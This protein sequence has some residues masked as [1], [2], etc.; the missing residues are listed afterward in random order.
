MI[1]ET[2][3]TAMEEIIFRIIGKHYKVSER[4]EDTT[5]NDNFVLHD[6]ELYEILFFSE[7]DAKF[8]IEGKEYFLESGD[9]I[10]VRKHEMHRVYHN[11]DARY[12]RIV[13]F[14][15]PEFFNIH[16]CPNYE[17]QFLNSQLGIANRIK[18]DYVR[19]CGLYDA[20]KRLRRYSKNY[21]PED[22]AVVEAIIIEILYLINRVGRFSSP[23][24]HE[25]Q[26]V[27]VISYINNHYTEDIDL[28]T[29]EKKFYTSRYHLCKIFRKA[30]GLTIHDYIRRKRLTRVREL[31]QAG[32]NITDAAM[33]SGF[34]DYS[35]FYR[36]YKKMMGCSPKGNI[37]NLYIDT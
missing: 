11:S 10:I 7:G 1:K 2:G 3:D 28:E 25:S 35:S 13:L 33:L 29:L 23:D 9:M 14:V 26:V 20:F 8:V 16:N 6:H 21:T 37:D 32:K 4:V 18:S 19:S 5:N 17:A 36:T 22:K 31:R 24:E 34:S 27:Q 12:Q 15:E 30:T